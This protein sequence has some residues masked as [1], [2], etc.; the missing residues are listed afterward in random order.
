MEGHIQDWFNEKSL[1]ILAEA[2]ALLVEED[3]GSLVI[4]KIEVLISYMRRHGSTSVKDLINDL[5]A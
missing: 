5:W 1:R 3:T 4:E 2:Q